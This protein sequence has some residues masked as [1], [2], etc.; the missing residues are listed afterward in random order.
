[1]N[2]SVTKKGSKWYM[3][4]YMLDEEGKKKQKWITCKESK[5]EKQAKKE[6]IKKQIE[7]ETGLYTDS[8]NMTMF[9]LLKEYVALAEKKLEYNTMQR[10]ENIIN[11]S[12]KPYFCNYKVDKVT[13]LLVQ[14][15]ITLLTKETK[16][17]STI[18]QHI[19]VLSN[20][21]RQ[22]KKWQLIQYDPCAELELPRVEKKPIVVWSSDQ[23]KKFFDYIQDK[24]YFIPMLIALTTGARQG[25]ISALA[26]SDFDTNDGYLKIGKSMN[27]KGELKSTKTK[28]IR[29]FKLPATTKKELD[30]HLRKLR[31]SRMS[32]PDYNKDNYLCWNSLGHPWKPK[33]LY[34]QFVTILDDIGLPHIRFHDLRHSFATLMLED[35]S[36]DIKTVSEMLGHAKISTTQQIYQHV[37]ETMKQNLADNIE[38]TFFKKLEVH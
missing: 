6:L 22:A 33:S 31:I 4:F 23:C 24:Q 32:N 26:I 5:T 14:N 7:I 16:A 2:G 11:T 27:R 1:M 34:T 28:K 30:K 37:T 8:K 21:M 13:P 3:I 10:Y 35:G 25:E 36:I 38:S 19:I 20:A 9:E 17:P 15:Y 12:I 18:R 29:E